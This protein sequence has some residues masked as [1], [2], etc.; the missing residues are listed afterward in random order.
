MDPA[1]LQN[2]TQVA[3]TATGDWDTLS[4]G[5]KAPFLQLNS[6][7]TAKAKNHFEALVETEREI[8]AAQSGR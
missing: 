2:A 8:M 3:R 4:E 6:N 7:N 1:Q 5:Q